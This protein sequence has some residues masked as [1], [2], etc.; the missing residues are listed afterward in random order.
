MGTQVTPEIR[1][2]FIELGSTSNW[3]KGNP[4]TSIHTI[5]L[6]LYVNFVNNYLMIWVCLNIKGFDCNYSV[7]EDDME[8]YNEL[9]EIFLE[10]VEP[11]Q[12]NRNKL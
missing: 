6:G 7:Y 9:Y 3:L 1:D 12:F 8:F 4:N 2:D 11:E 5:N 10:V